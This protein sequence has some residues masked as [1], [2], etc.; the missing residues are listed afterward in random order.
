MQIT[1][2]FI[3]GDA[4]NKLNLFGKESEKKPPKLGQMMSLR[5]HQTDIKSVQLLIL[6]FILFFQVIQVIFIDRWLYLQRPCASNGMDEMRN[7]R[8][9]CAKRMQ[10]GAWE[11]FRPYGNCEAN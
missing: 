10:R 8:T 1:F 6:S 4:P 3:C 5:R 7:E 9:I 2:F 11:A